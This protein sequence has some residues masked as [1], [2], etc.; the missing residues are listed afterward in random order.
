M[1]IFHFKHSYL[2][3]RAIPRKRRND[4]CFCSF[5]TFFLFSF[6]LSRI[7]Q[8]HDM[9]INFLFC[10][11]L[12]LVLMVCLLRATT[13]IIDGLPAWSISSYIRTV[14]K[15]LTFGS[16]LLVSFLS[17]GKIWLKSILEKWAISDQHAPRYQSGWFQNITVLGT[18]FCSWKRFGRFE[19]VSKSW[20]IP[21]YQIS[22]F[23]KTRHFVTWFSKHSRK[24]FWIRNFKA[25]CLSRRDQKVYSIFENRASWGTKVFRR[26]Q[27]GRKCLLGWVHYQQ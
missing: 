2:D 24:S 23:S 19:T 20:C 3:W 25:N 1:T 10:F 11:F 18:L 13:H 21:N 6:R 7:F 22:V 8:V 4:L 17:K 16:R 5:L 26:F 27:S 14:L 9:T 15:G 12:F